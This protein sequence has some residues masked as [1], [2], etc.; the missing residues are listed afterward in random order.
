MGVNTTVGFSGTWNDTDFPRDF[1][2]H[3]N[4]G[5]NWQLSDS[6]ILAGIDGLFLSQEISAWTQR[7]RKMRLSQI[8]EMFYR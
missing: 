5:G 7:I 6:E 1:I 3:G 2:M 4:R 8:F